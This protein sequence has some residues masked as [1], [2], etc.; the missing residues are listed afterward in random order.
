MLTFNLFKAFAQNMD[1]LII[2]PVLGAR[3][4]GLYTL[5]FRVVI[6][7]VA[8]L[9]GALG[10]YLFPKV[11]RLQADP[12][13]VR[14]VYRA[15]LVG[16]LNLVVPPLVAA[17]VL[18]PAIVPV[19]GD[20]WRDAIPVMQILVVVA[21]AQA[22]MA[23]VGQF[24][25][26]LGRPGWLIWWSVG[27]TLVIG[28]ALAIGARWGL[29]GAAVGFASAHLAALP[30][31]FLIGYRLTGLGVTEVVSVAWKPL[32]ATAALAALL[33]LG[34]P[35]LVRLNPWTVLA[36]AVIL[37]PLYLLASAQVNAELKGLVAREF[38]RALLTAEEPV[39]VAPQVFPS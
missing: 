7:P 24:M 33:V 9:V 35:Y 13:R 18:A 34:A 16:T 25:K 2:G 6:Y 15:V 1:R 19:L 32:I 31:I 30:I 12:V 26:G 11:A 5:A 39:A 3:A 36:G 29:S 8:S 4:L 14:A 37:G 10:A 17:A 23:P 20:R 38:R 21:V 22:L 27:L 28:I